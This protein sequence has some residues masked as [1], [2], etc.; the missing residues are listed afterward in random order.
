MVCAGR[1]HDVISTRE[2]ERSIYFV[3][4]DYLQLGWRHRFFGKIIVR[5]QSKSKL[6]VALGSL[7]PQ[8]AQF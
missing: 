6:N 2:L 4:L 7:G 8:F 3:V 5:Y 1:Y